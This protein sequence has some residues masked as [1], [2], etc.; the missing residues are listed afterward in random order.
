LEALPV[1]E[2]SPAAGPHI[3]DLFRQILA[4]KPHPEIGYRCCLGLVRLG[5]KHT[6]ARLE[7][8]TVLWT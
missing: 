4:T 3:A 2:H 6:I 5:E 8:G 7:A 1:R